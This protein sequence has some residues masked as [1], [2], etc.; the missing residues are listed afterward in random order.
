VKPPIILIGTMR[1]GT[2]WLGETF[3]RHPDLAYWPE[4][5][6]VW[7]W[8]HAYRPDYLLSAEDATP[9]I[10]R[11]IRKTFEDFVESR[12]AERFMEKTPSNCLRVPFIHKIFPEARIIL[13]VRDGRA[14][15][16]SSRE[17]ARRGMPVGSIRSRALATPIWEWPAYAPRAASAIWRKVT[18]RP[19]NYWG[20]RPPGWKRWV[21]EGPREVALAKVWS[22]TITR[23]VEDVRALPESSAIEFRYEDLMRDPA[24]IM[25]RVVD[26]CELPGADDLVDEVVRS[27]DASRADKWRREFDQETLDRIRP[28]MEPT[29]RW[30][31]YEW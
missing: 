9:R 20:P 22:A 26:F 24:P 25:R 28:H 13:I 10:K 3:S 18:R 15:I 16:R 11:H 21:R 8:G 29:L 6:H 19:L 2:T 12:G 7:S 31:G 27:A 5:R 4:P 14:V 1:S 30:L 17:I 23:A